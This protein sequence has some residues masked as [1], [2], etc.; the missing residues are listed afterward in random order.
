[1]DQRARMFK[2]L[3]CLALAMTG[4]AGLLSWIEPTG[5]GSSGAPDLAQVVAQARQAVTGD[6][7]VSLGRWCQIDLSLCDDRLAGRTDVLA[8]V[9]S[10]DQYH[11]FVGDAGVV[12]ANACWWEQE[13]IARHGDAVRVG[14]YY[15][16]GQ[17]AVPLP[18]A[19]ALQALVRE[20]NRCCAAPS[21]A[22]PVSVVGEFGSDEWQAEFARGL[23]ELLASSSG[24]R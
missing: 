15:R 10:N 20:L 7:S 5:P 18:Q 13:S 2:V 21:W 19:I 9:P 4:A 14:V 11:F 16:S 22:L 17:S 1:M 3:T 6:T 12:Q 8:A 23:R 24:A